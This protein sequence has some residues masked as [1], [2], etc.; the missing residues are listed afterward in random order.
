M[1]EEEII[2]IL[3]DETDYLCEE[4]DEAIK[5]LLYLYNKEKQKNKKLEKQIE[6]KVMNNYISK[7][8]IAKTFDNYSESSLMLNNTF[9]EFKKDLLG[10][11][12]WQY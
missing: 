5:G 9:I 3:K 1:S 12:Y 10:E 2:K 4:K 6:A 8:K 11:E 7:D